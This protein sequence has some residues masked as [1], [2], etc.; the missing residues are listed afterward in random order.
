MNNQRI[1]TAAQPFADVVAKVNARREA[2][3]RDNDPA[4]ALYA[5][6]DVYRREYDTALSRLDQA[7]MLLLDR[8]AARMGIFP[9]ALLEKADQG[10]AVL[11][12]IEGRQA[13]PDWTLDARGRVKPFHLDIAREFAESGQQH[14]FKFMSYLQFMGEKTLEFRTELPKRSLK[15]V[16]RAVGI[17]QGSCAVLVRTPMFEA[18]DRALKN[19]VIMDAFLNN[20]GAAL[21]RIGGMGNPNEGG[22]S[23]GFLARHVPA[24]LP[25]RER[26]KREFQ[27]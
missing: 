7:D 14:Y 5:G 23:E 20:M 19:R 17:T 8:A 4:A 21:T 22:V 26:W 18:A 10:R 3:L 2:A 16:F 15:D 25:N 27:I 13:V 12:E 11:I 6:V 1:F 24:D 9:K